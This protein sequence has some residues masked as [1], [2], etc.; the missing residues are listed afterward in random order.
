VIVD[1]IESARGGA[2]VHRFMFELIDDTERHYGR[3]EVCGLASYALGD[4]C[5]V[6]WFNC[7][8]VCGTD[9]SLHFHGTR[10]KTE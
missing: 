4:I 6:C 8:W 1:G 9:H 5:E 7:G 2:T 10:G 3:Y